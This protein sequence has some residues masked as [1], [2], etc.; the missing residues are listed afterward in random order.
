[1]RPNFYRH[2]V[3]CSLPRLK[4]GFT[5]LELMI[6]VA[7]LAIIVMLAVPAYMDYST[8]AK[9][10]E[11]LSVAAAAK[12][13]VSE[14]CQTNPLV[15]P[16]NSS[17]GYSF[18]ASNYVES[19]E[20]GGTCTEP[21]VIMTTKNTGASPAP[22]LQLTGNYEETAGRFNWNCTRTVGNNNLV[23]SRCRGT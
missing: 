22:V 7:I 15:D 18:S 3:N 16:T 23:P 19:I 14:A 20:V 8:R 9:V 2:Q 11:S 12:T 6:V 10:S 1:M 17:V 21:T 13:S 4:T 5:L